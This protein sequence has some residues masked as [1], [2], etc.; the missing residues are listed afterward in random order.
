[1]Q[2]MMYLLVSLIGVNSVPA[3]SPL[4]HTLVLREGENVRCLPRA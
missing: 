4:A 3:Y 2:A 1:M